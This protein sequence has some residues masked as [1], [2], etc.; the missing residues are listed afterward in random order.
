MAIRFR[1]NPGDECDPGKG[2]LAVG[3][4]GYASHVDQPLTG[5]LG[6]QTN[7]NLIPKL[8]GL[9]GIDSRLKLPSRFKLSGPTN[10]AYTVT[11]VAD[12]Y[13]SNYSNNIPANLPDQ[14]FINIVGKMKVPFFDEVK[15]HLHTSARTNGVTPKPPVWLAGGWPRAGSGIPNYGWRVGSNDFFTAGYFDENNFGFPPGVTLADYRNNATPQY[16]PRAQKLWLG[17]VDFDYPLRW[18]DSTRTFK[19][20]RS[21]SNDLLVLKVQ[22]E[23][24]Y[25]DPANAS[26][27]FGIQY[28]GL[29]KIS[30][31]NMAF[32]AIEGQL[33]VAQALANAASAEVRDVL[34][35]GLGNLDRLLA[36][37]LD[38][39]LDPVFQRCVDPTMDALYD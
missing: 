21:V 20:L 14:G 27:D 6:F 12:A 23:V 13:Y 4:R 24:T 30:L 39:F 36:A 11:P 19:S 16:H 32:N 10:T 33:G 5:F 9:A 28:D 31:A 34:L 2:L 3:A 15:V 7:G 35:E 29:P 26:L 37:R 18:T 38:D 22:H 25:L 1:S 17:V 8:F